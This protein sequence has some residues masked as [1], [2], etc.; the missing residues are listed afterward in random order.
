MKEWGSPDAAKK[1]QNC[2]SS[3]SINCNTWY[4]L[5]TSNRRRFI[6]TQHDVLILLCALNSSTRWYYINNSIII[7]LNHYC[8]WISLNC[9]CI[10]LNREILKHHYYLRH[11]A[12]QCSWAGV[13]PE[14]RADPEPWRCIP[15]SAADPAPRSAAAS[16]DSALDRWTSA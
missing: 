1:A 4:W 3:I 7:I 9:N 6:K 8:I 13:G 10:E 14:R 15:P 12:D 2:N 16:G 5:S 11:W